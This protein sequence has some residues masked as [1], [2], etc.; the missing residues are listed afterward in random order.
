MKKVLIY[1]TLLIVVLLG[2]GFVVSL[3]SHWDDYWAILNYK[4]VDLENLQVSIMKIVKVVGLFMLF[5]YLNKQSINL[6][7]R[8]FMSQNPDSAASKTV[9]AKNV[10]QVFVWG[11][12]LLLSLAILHISV[13][14]LIAIT[15]GL[16]TGIGF[17]SKNIIENIFY[18]LSLMTGRM[19]VGDWIE[20]NNTTGRVTNI[21]YTSTVVESL[22]GEVITFQNSQLFTYNY[23]NLTRNHRYVLA[24]VYY[25]VAYG[26][27]LQQVINVVE[28]ATNKLKK[29]WMDPSKKIVSVVGELGDSGV[30]MKLFVWVTAPKLSSM[31]SEVLSCIYDTLK[32]NN[33]SI[34]FP[35]RDIHIVKN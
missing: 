7:H 23:K 31:T 35:Q 21:S 2:I 5:A 19:K 1:T 6:L 3:V 30:N 18:G 14:W 22:Y 29:S 25:S 9:M 16:S 32:A 26:S 27:D 4:F 12:W 34:P 24:V 11:L 28:E 13:Q 10:V 8:H 15:G 33:I 17:A 20:V